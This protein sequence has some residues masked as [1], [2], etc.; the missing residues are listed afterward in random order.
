M[1]HLGSGPGQ[2]PH[3]NIL[4]GIYRIINHEDQ[5]EHEEKMKEE[6]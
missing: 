6:N 5:E 4:D 1:N 3:T 2:D